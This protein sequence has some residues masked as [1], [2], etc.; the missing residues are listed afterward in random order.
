MTEIFRKNIDVTYVI[1]LK[2]FMMMV[3]KEYKIIF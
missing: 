3:T 2:K 1:R